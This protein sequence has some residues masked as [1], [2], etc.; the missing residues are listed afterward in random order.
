MN[1]TAV[2]VV[3]RARQGL[4]L[5]LVLLLGL[6]ILAIG[7][8]MIANSG[9]YLKSSADSKA[10]LRARYAAEGMIAIQM[11]KLDAL[12]DQ[13]MGANLNLSQVPLSGLNTGD[14]ERAQ[15]DPLKLASP[16]GQEVI[17][18][19]LFRGMKG[20]KIPFLIQA[21]GVTPGGGKAKIDAD[22]YLY[23]VP[24]FQFGVFFEGD[25]EI[26]PG[27]TM[28]VFG[29]VHT[30]SNAY[31]RAYDSKVLTIE[32]PVTAVGTIY[33]WVKPSGQLLYYATPG[34]G[35]GTAVS[36][37]TT[38]M[39]AM[40]TSPAPGN[41]TQGSQKLVLPIGG[42]SPHELISLC[43]GAESDALKKQ[44]FDCMGAGAYRYHEGS[45]SVP[46]WLSAPR[47]FYDRRENRWVRFRDIDVQAALKAT[48]DSIFYFY[49]GTSAVDRGASGQT[50][51]EAYRIVN[52]ATLTRN[53]SITSGNPI[54]LLG[55]FNAPNPS[56]TCGPFGD[57]S[58]DP[59][60]KYC[61]AMIAS[62]ALT[63]LS[64][65]WT[66]QD[67]ANRSMMGTLEQ[68]A[69][70]AVWTTSRTWDSIPQQMSGSHTPKPA[71]TVRTSASE[72]GWGVP[73]LQGSSAVGYSS[74]GAP[75]GTQ[76]INAAILTGTKP[77]PSS[78]LA[79]ATVLN[80]VYD[81]G[82]E[83]GW[84]GAMRFLEDLGG[85][86]LNFTGSFVC[87]WNSASP[88]LDMSSNRSFL[89]F[90]LKRDIPTSKWLPYSMDGHFSPPVRNWGYD[91]RFR[92][93][94]NMPPGTPFLSTGIFANWAER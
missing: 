80:S 47:V 26:A 24:I 61:N 38:S 63:I 25:L 22:V 1:R 33:Q 13:A 49:D 6:V 90:S 9:G 12:K 84:I 83:G 92:D 8:A 81:A 77:T 76:T 71:A 62:D 34:V 88:G 54:Y 82:T 86:T 79:P 7:T 72:Q 78:Y 53:V 56:S 28:T 50:M 57:A 93:I 46:S 27:P 66:T 87:L 18:S 21:T 94:N 85:V 91:S 44:K 67:Y 31:F 65:S 36:G 64:N 55:D 73:S 42:S 10:R 52:A 48:A 5:G 17:G 29:P 23:Q 32:G 2:H 11:A 58:P 43:T 19:G 20:V 41:V 89:T 16:S 3:V 35:P 4:A 51:I 40:G 45:S 69:S 75:S 15:A 30:N 59:S 70:N 74:A 14:G 60:E 68:S 37:L 39:A